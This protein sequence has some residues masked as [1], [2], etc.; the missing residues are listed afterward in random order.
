VPRDRLTD[1]VLAWGE[2]HRRDLPWR[3]TRDPWAV[4]VAE[5]MLQQTQVT[6]VVPRWETFLVE[7]PTPAA[8]AAEPLAAVLE[9]W[10][11][12]GYPRRGRNLWLASQR[13]VERHDCRLPHTLP[14]L[15]DLPGVGAYTARAVLAFALEQPVGVV[16][17]NIARV[18]ARVTGERLTPSRAQAAAD[19]WVPPEA[20]WAWNQTLMDVGALRCRPAAPQCGDCPLRGHCGWHLAGHPDPDPAVGT[21]GA[22]GRQGRFAGSDRQGRGRLMAAMARGPLAVDDVASAAGWLDD[23]DRAA[24]VVDDL[25]AEGL[26]SRIDG[27]YL[28]G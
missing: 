7:L 9:R 13:C 25:V 22:S 16:D 1:G 3:R 27:H 5:V 28:L 21:A 8:C 2:R 19:G 18:L 12:L 11:G 17:T 10:Q 23:P 15:L 24:R 14:E 4:L 20:S 26:A 6:R